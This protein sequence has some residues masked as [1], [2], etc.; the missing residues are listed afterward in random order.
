MFSHWCPEGESLLG[1][2]RC[3]IRSLMPAAARASRLLA[4][5]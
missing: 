1:C 3:M 5:A 2:R 4:D